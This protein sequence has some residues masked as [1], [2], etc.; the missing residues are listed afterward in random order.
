MAAPRQL[1][2]DEESL[3]ES[4]RRTRTLSRPT[5]A[6][7]AGPTEYPPN[8]GS[9]TIDARGRRLA[10]DVGNRRR[11]FHGLPGPERAVAPPLQDVARRTCPAANPGP[12]LSH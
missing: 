4:I 7:F 10:L 8:N 6:R 12:L 1:C 3:R 2:R 11:I 9:A 5:V